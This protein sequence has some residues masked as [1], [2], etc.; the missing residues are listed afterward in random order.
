MNSGLERKRPWPDPDS[1]PVFIM[2]DWEKL[3]IISV[4]R[5]EIR[6]EHLLK[7][8]QEYYRLAMLLGG[9]WLSLMLLLLKIIV[10]K[11]VGCNCSRTE[12]IA[13]FCNN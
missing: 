2:N 11:G 9:V 5:A 7:M 1:M 13:V 10:I 12:G 6:N 4:R 3:R 8:N